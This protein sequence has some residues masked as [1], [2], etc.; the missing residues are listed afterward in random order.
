MVLKWKKIPTLNYYHGVGDDLEEWEGR[1]SCM[2]HLA[3]TCWRKDKIFFLMAFPCLFKEG[4]ETAANHSVGGFG[5]RIYTNTQVF[6]ITAY[7]DP[8]DISLFFFF[9]FNGELRRSK[10]KFL[11][12]DGNSITRTCFSKSDVSSRRGGR[13]LDMRS[14]RLLFI[15]KWNIGHFITS[16]FFF[17]KL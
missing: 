11:F 14:F 8:V 12:Q 10:R 1:F 15:C 4:V 13:F 17:C 5:R 7:N 16:D 9:H 6:S 3:T 2:G